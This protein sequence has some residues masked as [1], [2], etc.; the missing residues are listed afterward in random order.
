MDLFDDHSNMPKELAAI[1]DKYS[2]KYEDYIPKKAIDQFLSEVE[3]IGYTFEYG[4]DL[5]PFG[6]RPIGT[7]LEE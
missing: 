5:V 7:N 4:L 3:K 2:Q 6:L 1:C